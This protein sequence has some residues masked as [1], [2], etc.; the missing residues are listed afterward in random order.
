MD[1]TKGAAGGNGDIGP[2]RGTAEFINDRD[3]EVDLGGGEF[4]EV[5]ALETGAGGDKSTFSL[6]DH[7]ELAL[8][9][10]VV[11]VDI[12]DNLVRIWL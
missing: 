10:G 2:I 7:L 9:V 8:G 5:E 12:S 11:S 4:S 1:R 6:S 3:E